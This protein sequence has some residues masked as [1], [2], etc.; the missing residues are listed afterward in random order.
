MAAVPHLKDGYSSGF[1]ATT[2]DPLS[3]KAEPSRAFR[4]SLFL[5]LSLWE[6]GT[7]IQGSKFHMRHGGG[8]ASTTATSSSLSLV[9]SSLPFYLFLSFQCSSLTPVLRLDERQF[10]SLDA[11]AYEDSPLVIRRPL[12]PYDP[13]FPWEKADN[14]VRVLRSCRVPELM[15]I[16][17]DAA[18]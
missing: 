4:A 14:P 6:P 1:V 10:L 13:P 12:L 8:T 9:Y 3:Q 11:K 17:L 18:G 5:S 2:K 7:S 16:P 15:I